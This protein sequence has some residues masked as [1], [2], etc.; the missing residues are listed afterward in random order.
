MVVGG[1]DRGTVFGEDQRVEVEFARAVGEDEPDRAQVE[2]LAVAEGGQCFQ[3]GVFVVRAVEQVE[4]A[5]V[6]RPVAEERV[7]APAA[8]QPHPGRAHGVEDAQDRGRVRH[9][10]ARRSVIT[11]ATRRCR[12]SADCFAL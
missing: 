7:D 10:P 2:R 5:V 4:V 3:D 12:V 9:V 11:L 8:R 6:A 1:L